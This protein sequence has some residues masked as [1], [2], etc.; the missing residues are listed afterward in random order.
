MFSY[1]LPI[2]LILGW[3]STKYLVALGLIFYYD[4]NFGE[5]MIL[6]ITSSMMGVV[7]F[8]YTRNALKMLWYR[9]RP[10]PKPVVVKVNWRTR[11]IAK[12]RSRFGLAGIA[13]LTPILLSIPVGSMMAM[14]LYKNKRMV[15]AYMFASICFWSLL[16]IGSYHALGIDITA[17]INNIIH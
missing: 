17:S 2:L 16:F 5:S 1:F 6:A 4:Y 14:S 8:S 9:L 12:T 7:F 15:F 10:E 11:L 13:F 3:G